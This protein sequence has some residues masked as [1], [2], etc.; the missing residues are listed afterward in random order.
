MMRMREGRRWKWRVREGVDELE[1]GDCP[2]SAQ[3]S[4]RRASK[5]LETKVE[6][7]SHFSKDDGERRRRLRGRRESSR[8]RPVSGESE[9]RAI[10]FPVF[11]FPSF[12]RRSFVLDSVREF[13]RKQCLFPFETVKTYNTTRSAVCHASVLP[14][15]SPLPPPPLQAKQTMSRYRIEVVHPKRIRWRR[16]CSWG[17]CEGT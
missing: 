4:W 12:S 14:P 9:C 6:F 3:Q 7:E 8:T 5:A 2:C 10:L 11:S 16:D 13:E 15:P 17:T 1:Q